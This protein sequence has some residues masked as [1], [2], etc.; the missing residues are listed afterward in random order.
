M[1]SNY[2]GNWILPESTAERP[3]LDSKIKWRQRHTN[4]LVYQ[5]F[6]PGIL[7]QDPGKPWMA[8][9]QSIKPPTYTNVKQIS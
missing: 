7:T 2:S 5:D 3:W 6:L 8:Q 1:H 4:A 9:A